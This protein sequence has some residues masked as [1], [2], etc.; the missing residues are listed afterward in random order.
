[1]TIDQ[2]VISALSGLGTAVVSDAVDR[3]GIPAQASGIVR[4]TGHGTVVGTAFTVRY[5]P[6]GTVGG[7][8]G[9]YID[10]VEPGSFIVLSNNARTDAT[11][12]GGLLSEISVKRGIAGTAIDGICRDTAR[13]ESV[14][15]S[16][17][18]R[19]HWMRTGK[20]RVRA[21]EMQIPVALGDMLVR[22]GDVLVG[23]ADGIVVLPFER[24]SEIAEIAVGIEV[25]EQRIHEDAVE[26]GMRL[27]EARK[28]RGYHSLQSKQ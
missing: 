20:D 28:L 13:A 22:P 4:I 19:S 12:W 11:V 2:E 16:L 14:G 1:M 21:E 10:D 6:V 18:A 8:V 15:Y 27:D 23:D 25:A 5:V 7:T 17:F 24:A 9:D 3:L 26:G